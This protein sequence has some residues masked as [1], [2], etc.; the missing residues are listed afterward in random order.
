MKLKMFDRQVGGQF[1]G[2]LFHIS[3]N[4]KNKLGDGDSLFWA[5]I[6]P[7]FLKMHHFVAN[8]L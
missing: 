5:L 7:Y 1:L 4:F 6:S 2:L 8:A 3:C